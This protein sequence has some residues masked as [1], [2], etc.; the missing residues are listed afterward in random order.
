M[1]DWTDEWVT[2]V[3]LRAANDILF[4]QLGFL[5]WEFIATLPFD[6]SFLARARPFTWSYLIYHSTRI[7]AVASLVCGVKKVAWLSEVD[8]TTWG[9]GAFVLGYTALGLAAALLL[10]RTIAICGLRRWFF[11]LT[12]SWYTT[13][14]AVWF[15]EVSKMSFYWVPGLNVC[16]TNTGVSTNLINISLAAAFDTLCLVSIV[17][18][19]RRGVP[20]RSLWRLLHQQGVL[21]FIIVVFGH[22]ISIT[23]LLVD[24]NQ[25][26]TEMCLMF[27]ML[28]NVICATRMYR[29]LI[30]F[31]DVH[32]VDS[33][34]TMAHCGSTHFDFL[35]RPSLHMPLSIYMLGNS[36]TTLPTV[37][38]HE[39]RDPR[40]ER[41]HTRGRPRRHSMPGKC[42]ST[43]P[44]SVDREL[45]PETSAAGRS[46]MSLPV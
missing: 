23:F 39:Q 34:Q 32:T 8:C 36:A 17:V 5:V 22:A 11:A 13:N 30:Q 26:I 42:P 35:S 24:L 19:L 14:I 43:R 12:V 27:S 1:V 9:Y 15:Y 46:S 41:R 3:S 40:L 16:A 18:T 7:A 37:L 21:W 20:G 28:N 38:S 10:Q 29:G 45:E 44:Q 31:S 33:L 25:P 6:F 4:I 2:F